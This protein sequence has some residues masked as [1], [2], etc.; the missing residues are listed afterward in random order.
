[1]VLRSHFLPRILVYLDGPCSVSISWH[2]FDRLLPEQYLNDSLIELGLMYVLPPLSFSFVFSWPYFKLW[3]KALEKTN[4]GPYLQHL[5]FQK[6]G[7]RVSSVGRIRTR[8]CLIYFQKQLQTGEK[9]DF[10][11]Q[12]VP[13]EIH[14]GSDQFQPGVSTA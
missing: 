1:M 7:T 14:S 6:F 5:L 13:E 4:P 8:S 9:V 12:L 3:L 10:Q 2:D 11:A